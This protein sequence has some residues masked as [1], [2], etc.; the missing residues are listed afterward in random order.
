MS[1]AISMPFTVFEV[2]EFRIGGTGSRPGALIARYL[3]GMTYRLTNKNKEFVQQMVEDG[4]AQYGA[5]SAQ[6][7]ALVGRVTG[8]M[9]VKAK[10]KG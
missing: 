9:G 1:A 5:L 3:P 2:T 8:R 10:K 6:Q 4:K 7:S